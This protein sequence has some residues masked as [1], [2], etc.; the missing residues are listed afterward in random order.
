M[1]ATRWSSA[2]SGF[3]VLVLS[4]CG[5]TLGGDRDVQPIG[6]LTPGPA[7]GAA[8]YFG[9]AFAPCDPV[10]LRGYPGELAAPSSDYYEGPWC[11]SVGERR[12]YLWAYARPLSRIRDAAAVSGEV[13]EDA[14]QMVLDLEAQGFHR[15][16]GTVLP[17]VAVDAAFEK[18]GSPARIHV[19]TTGAVSNPPQLTSTE[20]LSL[21]VA[22]AP[23]QDDPAIPQGAPA[24][25]CP[26]QAGSP[27][28]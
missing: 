22:V 10:Q 21:T 17:G 28:P 26:W 16:C 20:P 27:V 9:E 5:L 11:A 19:R 2:L 23:T 8:V 7:P 14:D 3:A 12:D 4:G 24:P 1:R 6:V 15:V 25:P 18:P 13:A